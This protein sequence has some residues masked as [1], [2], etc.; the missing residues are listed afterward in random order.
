MGSRTNSPPP[1]F[2]HDPGTAGRRSPQH[3]AAINGGGEFIPEQDS[4]EVR[5]F[6][7]GGSAL[8]VI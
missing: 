4:F 5:G 6:A 7:C 3:F 1:G 8:R 2:L